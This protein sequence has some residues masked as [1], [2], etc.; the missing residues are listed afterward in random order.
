VVESLRSKY[1]YKVFLYG[2]KV[3]PI[4]WALII[5]L[6]NLLAYFGLHSEIVSIVVG[7]SVLPWLSV[8]AASF[9]FRFCICHRLYLYY[10]GTSEAVAWY[11]F[12]IGFP[13]SD[14]NF[15]ILHSTL[16]V[17]TLLLVTYFHVKHN[18]R[19]A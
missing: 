16:F 6:N 14:F 18:K 5:F 12:K 9:V 4:I 15:L 10:V 7:V 17:I 19:P 2:L 11:D 8:L 1:L 13:I 3:F